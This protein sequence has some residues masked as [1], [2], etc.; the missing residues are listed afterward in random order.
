MTFLSAFVDLVSKTLKLLTNTCQIQLACIMVLMIITLLVQRFFYKNSRL[1][2]I[3]S[4]S[5]YI[6][7]GY[8]M[9]KLVRHQKPLIQ[10]QT[11]EAGNST[12][13]SKTHLDTTKKILQINESC[14]PKVENIQSKNNKIKSHNDIEANTVDISSNIRIYYFNSDTLL[15]HNQDGIQIAKKNEISEYKVND[16]EA[17]HIILQIPLPYDIKKHDRLITKMYDNKLRDI[18]NKQWYENC[19]WV[20]FVYNYEGTYVSGPIDTTYIKDNM[21]CCKISLNQGVCTFKILQSPNKLSTVQLHKK[22]FPGLHKM[23]VSGFPLISLIAIPI[24][25]LFE[26]IM[27]ASHSLILSI[28]F[29]LLLFKIL[30]FR[31]NYNSYKISK[32]P[33]VSAQQQILQ[34]SDNQQSYEKA[35]MQAVKNNMI[36]KIGPILLRIISF[37]VISRIIHTSGYL[38]DYNSILIQPWFTLTYSMRYAAG[39]AIYAISHL[40][41]LPLNM[42]EIFTKIDHNFTY[43]VSFIPKVLNPQFLSIAALYTTML[44]QHMTP[45]VDF[46]QQS[47]QQNI[48]IFLVL[49]LIFSS[50]SPVTCLYLIINGLT[51]IAQLYAFSR[52]YSFCS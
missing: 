49:F 40:V 6:F 15:D 25:Q 8:L 36:S 35:A 23:F 3:I 38:Q 20:G 46:Q 34:F 19:K 43:I 12:I 22:D 45:K 1:L 27:S 33:L 2:P 44:E 14:D 13:E 52:I 47:N 4:L 28:L 51:E 10:S 7:S 39:Q 9:V 24:M 17:T 31:L 11:R 37:I 16:V 26:S 32:K 48:Y 18:K 42:N 29:I 50:L 30:F 5:L 21:L 41:N